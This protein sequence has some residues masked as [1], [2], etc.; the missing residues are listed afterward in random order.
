MRNAF[1]AMARDDTMFG[2]CYAISSDLGISPT[3]MRLAFALLLFWNPPAAIGGYAVAVALSVAA[4]AIVPEP[5]DVAAEAEAAVEAEEE[6]QE[7]PL[8]A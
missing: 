5:A 3:W 6:R 2:A 1:S 7:L 8:A 4:R